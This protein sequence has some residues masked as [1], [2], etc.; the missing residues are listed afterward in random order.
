M[1]RWGVLENERFSSF[2]SNTVSEE[3]IGQT[4]SDVLTAI[5]NIRIEFQNRGLEKN[6]IIGA[7]D[8]KDR[9]RV[10][11][12]L[13]E[14]YTIVLPLEKFDQDSKR[15]TAAKL[16]SAHSRML[17]LNK[18]LFTIIMNTLNARVVGFSPT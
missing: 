8:E 14:Y 7:V 4:F 13:E 5:M 6:A 10:R 11:Q 2:F 3:T 9:E 16:V 1:F 12:N 17:A 18:E 15:A